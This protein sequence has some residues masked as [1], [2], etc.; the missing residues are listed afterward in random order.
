M[1]GFRETLKL[2]I[3]CAGLSAAVTFPLSATAKDYKV[4]HYFKGGDDGA[5]PQGDLI[6][7]P[8][9]NLY[10]V[11]PLGGTKH[12]KGGNG[13]VFKLAP[14]GTY[15]VLYAFKGGSDG[16]LPFGDLVL[17]L[18]GNLYGTTSQGGDFDEGT[19]YRLASDGT[20]TVVYSF[21]A[22]AGDGRRPQAGLVT[23]KSGNLYGTTFEGGA[24]Q[25]GTVFKFT[26]AG[27]EKILYSFCA[28]AECA[29]G[30]ILPTGLIIDKDK[31][32]YGTTSS[33]GA[34]GKG[35]VFK[36]LADGSYMVLHSFAGAPT[37]GEVPDA[38]LRMDKA[39]NL[40]GTTQIGGASNAGTIFK[41]ASDG[42]ESVLHSFCFSCSD[43]A[44]PHSSLLLDNQGDLVGTASQN[45]QLGGGTAFR[46]ASGS[47]TVLHAF[48]L[49]SVDGFLVSAGLTSVNGRFYG[50]T[51]SGGKGC[52]GDGCGVMFELKP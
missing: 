32:L 11:T 15:T 19:I 6:A 44:L 46:L 22:F 26:Q 3:L 9:G 31:S 43:G 7:D 28:L 23:D 48:E 36:L 52:R 17:D 25:S 2:V 40:Y 5:H 8:T 51:T 20:K 18:A 49:H 14:D 24:F 29:D 21:G 33:G 50:T 1:A 45:G 39:G 4:L 35:T 41:I 13:V 30:A 16:Y 34:F 47:F 10:G 12:S 38:G 42:T 37:D 27:K